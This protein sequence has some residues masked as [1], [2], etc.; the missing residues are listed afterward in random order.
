MTA[1]RSGWETLFIEVSSNYFE[2]LSAGCLTGFVE[3]GL[4]AGSRGSA[5][6]AYL[7]NYLDFCLSSTGNGC[8]APGC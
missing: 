5:R 6:F 8:K 4:L 1:L 7:T 2:Q 3:A